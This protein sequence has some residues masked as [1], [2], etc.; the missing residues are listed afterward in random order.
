MPLAPCGYNHTNTSHTDIMAGII[1]HQNSLMMMLQNK[2]NNKPS[3]RCHP[4]TQNKLQYC[5]QTKNVL[6]F[7]RRTKTLSRP[8]RRCR[9]NQRSIDDEKESQLLFIQKRKEILSQRNSKKYT[10]QGARAR[11]PRTQRPLRKSNF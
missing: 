4:Q 9:K 6:Q 8:T 11:R 2:L 3:L 10:Y 5:Q 1:I 7:V